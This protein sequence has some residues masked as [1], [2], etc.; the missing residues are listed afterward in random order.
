M[1]ADSPNPI[2]FSP[3][4]HDRSQ[5]P[6]F[7]RNVKIRDRSSSLVFLDDLVYRLKYACKIIRMRDYYSALVTSHH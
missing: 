2:G 1:S 3:R 7:P 4:I 6:T 5:P